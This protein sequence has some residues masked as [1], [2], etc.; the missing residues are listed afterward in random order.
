[1]VRYNIGTEF[2]YKTLF[3]SS[4]DMWGLGCLIWEVFNGPLTQQS[5]LKNIDRV[6][7]FYYHYYI[8]KMYLII[9]FHYWKYEYGMK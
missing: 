1:M 4:Y 9:V 6:R 3:C 8:A 7:I 5:S 2:K